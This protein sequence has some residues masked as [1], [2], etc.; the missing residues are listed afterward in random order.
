MRARTDHL[1]AI[2]NL[3]KRVAEQEW[4]N[5]ESLADVLCAQIIRC[6]R[7]ELFPMLLQHCPSVRDKYEKARLLKSKIPTIHM[8]D[9]V[10]YDS[11]SIQSF[12]ASK[13]DI[14]TAART[15]LS[16][17]DLSSTCDYCPKLPE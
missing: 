4:N 6:D 9:T 8:D 7:D 1:I 5:Y 2:L 3:L 17:F 12:F 13:S 11:A 10:D 15:C 16:N 14:K